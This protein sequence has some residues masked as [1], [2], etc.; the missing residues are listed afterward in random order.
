VI[1]QF[2]ANGIVAGAVY[3]IVALGFGLIYNTTKVFHIAH[4]AAYTLSAYIFYT[5]YRIIGL[6]IGFSLIIGLLSGVFLGIIMEFL[7]YRPL[8][9]RRVPSGIT[10]VSSIGIYIFIVNLIAML[11]G[12]E[13]KV[14]S[15]GIEKTYEIFGVILTRIQIFEIVAFVVVFVLY[16]LLL[17][18][19]NFGRLIRALANNPTLLSTFGIESSTL[20][21]GIFALG[22]L[23]AGMSSCLVAL[24][25]GIDPNIGMPALLI[26]AVAMIIG[27][28]GI[29]ESAVIGGFTIGILQNLIVW[30]IS[31]RWQEA[32]T[33]LLLILFLLLRPQGILGKR[34]RVEEI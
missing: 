24:D 28:I 15:P 27:G 6:P 17:K 20:R 11:Y 5:F 32:I 9:E 1:P 31:A 22:S 13:T 4:G 8:Y 33:F 30:R 21:I 3:S 34:R 12:N 19:T 29:F 25:V 23:F 10:L 26:S 18:K 14:L 2:L 16:F 7:V